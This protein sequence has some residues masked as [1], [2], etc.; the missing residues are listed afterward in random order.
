MVIDVSL[1]TVKAAGLPPKVTDVAPV[2]LDPV[3]VSGV[4]PTAAPTLVE[5]DVITG[6][7]H[8]PLV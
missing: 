7:A 4:E 2:K 5:S 8:S 3:I 1:T 6:T